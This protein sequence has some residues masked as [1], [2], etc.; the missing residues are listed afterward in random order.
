MRALAIDLGGSHA[1]CGVVEDALIRARR[2]QRLNGHAT[3]GAFLPAIGDCLKGILQSCGLRPCDCSALVMGFCGLVDTDRGRVLSTSGKFGDAPGLD[4]SQWASAAFGLPF[5]IENDARLA[6]LGEQYAGAA[7]GS[8]DVVMITLGSGV[9]GAAMIDGRLLRGKHFQAGCL[10]GHFPVEMN[11]RKCT[12]GNVGCV[13]AE[14]STWA[15]AE[16]CRSCPGFECSIL[17]DASEIDFSVLFG[18]IDAGDGF[19][20]DILRHCTRVWGAGA[21]ALVHAYD[22]EIV[23]VGGGV[24]SR[25]PLIIPEMRGY[26]AEHAWTPWGEVEVRAAE[27]GNDAALVGAVPLLENG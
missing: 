13:E 6:L 7:R 11:G 20:L 21:V 18:A 1:T 16:I 2:V 24:M 23:V 17:R 5:R 8:N 15:L 19:A 4:L 25:W 22:P 10:G 12:C 27:L 9:G 14:A 26:V 3:L